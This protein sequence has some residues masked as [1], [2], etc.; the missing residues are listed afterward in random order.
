MGDREIEQAVRDHLDA[1]G[2]PYEVLPCD[3]ALADT[4]A[5]CA[6]YGI[7]PEHSANCIIVASRREPKRYC[8]CLA[9][10]TTRL[11][12]NK[13]VKRLLDA[14]RV[15]F[16]PPDET[17]SLTGMEIGGVTPFAL[18]ADLPLYVDRRVL[19]APIVWVGGGSRSLKIGIAPVIF[20][21]MPN[22]TVIDDLAAPI[23]G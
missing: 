8:A 5:F 19:E 22:V 11:D 4:A 14:G 13:T 20:S 3:P 21:R 6:H 23:D 17:R 15:S 16:A 12:V 9:L 18:P 7:A 10:A 1:L 2:E